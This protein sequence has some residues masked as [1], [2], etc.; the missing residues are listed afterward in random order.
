MVWVL[1]MS[2]VVVGVLST[3]IALVVKS[4]YGLYVMCSDLMYV[5]L[6][7]QFT[8]VLFVPGTNPYGGLAGFLLSLTLRLFS[9]DP[10]IGLKPLIQFPF[11]SDSAGQR[12]PFRTL[13]MLLGFSAI[14]LGSLAA[15][16]V[17]RK[18]WLSTKWDVFG[19]FARPPHSKY[20]IPG[21]ECLKNSQTS[22]IKLAQSC[23]IAYPSSERDRT[24]A[25]KKDYF[26]SRKWNV[27]WK[28]V[29]LPESE[30]S[31]IAVKVNNVLT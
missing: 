2:I 1:R 4:V 5:I 19:Y 3:L 17:F 18:G 15:H 20:L 30:T 24:D 28:V 31:L 13:A 7:P 25:N 26:E 11:F 6:F 8:C 12:F 16:V 10:L 29:P 9:G 27:D 21:M 22:S 14:L 23:D